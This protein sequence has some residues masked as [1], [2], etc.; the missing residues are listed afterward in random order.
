M[1]TINWRKPHSRNCGLWHRDEVHQWL[2]RRENAG[3]QRIA[4]Q[5]SLPPLSSLLRVSPIDGSLPEARGHGSTLMQSMQVRFLENRKQDDRMACGT[6]G[7]KKNDPENSFWH[8]CH[9]GFSKIDSHFC[10]LL[11]NN[12]CQIDRTSWKS[13]LFTTW[14]QPFLAFLHHCLALSH[15]PNS[16]L[17]RLCDV[18]EATHS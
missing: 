9:R 2:P 5:P 3:R 15:K 1:T 8:G 14:S 6:A 16:N 12:Y 13:K 11:L 10:F 18:L 4:Y 17:I 7:A